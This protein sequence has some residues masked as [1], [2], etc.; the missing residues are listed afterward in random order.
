MDTIAEALT[1]AADCVVVHSIGY[2]LTLYRD[3][4]LPRRTA[5]EAAA[6]LALLGRGG[7]GQGAA[8]GSGAPS[9][10][11]LAVATEA[12]AGQ[13]QAAQ[14]QA[15]Q[16]QQA[17]QQQQHGREEGGEAGE[18]DEEAGSGDEDDFSDDDSDEDAVGAGAE[19][20]VVTIGGVKRRVQKPPEFTIIG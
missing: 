2:T 8:S 18:G 9:S 17:V 11:S 16:Q 1:R 3:S 13:Q 20:V 4:S 7:A 15:A 10:G 12:A 19:E 14:Q 5:A 6:E